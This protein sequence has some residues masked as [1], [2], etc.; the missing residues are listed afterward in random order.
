MDLP[1]FVAA[2]WRSE[3]LPGSSGRDKPRSEA[4]LPLRSDW[5][6]LSETPDLL[7]VPPVVLAANK[8]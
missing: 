3:P 6:L 2:A 4:L 8:D 5:S 7:E 1:A